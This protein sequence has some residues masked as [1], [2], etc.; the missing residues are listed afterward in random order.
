M[1][2]PFQKTL[3]LWGLLLLSAPLLEAAPFSILYHPTDRPTEYRKCF[4]DYANR[5][6][7]PGEFHIAIVLGYSDGTDEGYDLV[8]D[9]DLRQQVAFHLTK[10]CR[11]SQ[12]GFCE[13]NALN[14]N[15]H[16][17]QI[18]EREIVGPH[19]RTNVVRVTLMDSSYDLS[20]TKNKTIYQAQQKAKTERA[21]SFFAESLKT[22]DVIFYE[23]HSR[24][25]GGPDFAPPRSRSN[26]KVDYPW[27]RQNQPGLKFL[28]Q[29]LSNVE[30]SP[31]H[32]GLFS[33]ASHRHFRKELEPLLHQSHMILSTK[34]VEAQLTKEALLA[35]IEAILN[36]ECADS[37]QSRIRPFSFVV[38]TTP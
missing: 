27:Y 30:H 10:L 21:R 28:L 9:Q 22:S 26:G 5:F 1:G 16:E 23:G 13:F 33:C 18:F 12:Q 29:A 24:D 19:G 25:G 32:L 8:M 35:S 7:H 17:P 6:K 4:G 38:R 3:V 36:F 2:I 20:N 11:S 34:V 14:E 15:P 37:L 31:H